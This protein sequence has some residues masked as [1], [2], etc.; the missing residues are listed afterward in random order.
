M[1][2]RNINAANGLMNGIRF[3]LQKMDKNLM[4]L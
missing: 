4:H 1:L 2:L 3:M